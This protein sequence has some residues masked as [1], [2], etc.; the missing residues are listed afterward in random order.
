MPRKA[1][2]K[3]DESQEEITTDPKSMEELV[4][5]DQA[6]KDEAA[7]KAEEEASREPEKEEEVDLDKFKEEITTSTRETIEKEVVGP[8]KEQIDKL[9][10]T[11]TPDEKDE[12]DKWVEEFTEKNGKAPEWKQVAVF[13]KDQAKAEIK[14]EQ[15]ALQAQ[16]EEKQTQATKEQEDTANKNFKYWQEQLIEM[17][18]Q[19]MI[20][21]MTKPEEGDP[22]FDARVQLYG[23]MQ[24]TWKSQTPITNM[25]EVLTK[26]PLE[27][28]S[29]Q[30]AGDKAPVS[31]GNQ[32]GGIPDDPLR[33]KYSEVHNGARDI[34]SYAIKLM[35]EAQKGKSN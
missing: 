6:A 9:Q 15:E 14:A 29:A 12:Y 22:G 16:E 25:Y 17:E 20:P 19:G 27:A 5:E 33:P 10:K 2:P 31:L 21:N 11:Q 26:F 4:A 28:K 7:R 1:A 24:A 13:L 8:L 18:K 34:E 35:T 30:P 32:G 23:H 3:Q